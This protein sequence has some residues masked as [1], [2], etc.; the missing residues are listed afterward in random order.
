MTCR[1]LEIQVFIILHTTAKPHAM[2]IK[3]CRRTRKGNYQI[4]SNR[5]KNR[6]NN[7]QTG[8]DNYHSNLSRK[9]DAL[10]KLG[11]RFG[12][13][14]TNSMNKESQTLISI[15]NSYLTIISTRKILISKSI[16]VQ[17]TMSE[18]SRVS[19]RN[20]SNTQISRHNQTN[21]QQ[22]DTEYDEVDIHTKSATKTQI[23]AAVETR[24][25]Q[26]VYAQTTRRYIFTTD[27]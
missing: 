19:T 8:I 6:E 1:C 20:V 7:H 13:L 15:I 3:E 12:I 25:N 5:E 22:D 21:H 16:T 24:V 9:F 27:C 18:T 23:N 14:W 11:P 2:T 10:Q 26:I 17:H 4:N